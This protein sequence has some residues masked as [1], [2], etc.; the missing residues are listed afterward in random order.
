MQA[1]WPQRC[2]VKDPRASDLP[3][4]ADRPDQ[5]TEE[6]LRDLGGEGGP[7]G[8]RT[9]RDPAN[10]GDDVPD[11]GDVVY[12]PPTPTDLEM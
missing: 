1:Q 12:P 10:L 9:G 11:E 3:G 6:D 5:P 7:V 4:P 2:R 8:L